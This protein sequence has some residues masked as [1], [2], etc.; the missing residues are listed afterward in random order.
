MFPD[1]VLQQLGLY[2][3]PPP[4]GPPLALAAPPA[5]PEPEPLPVP[6]PQRGE[7]VVPKEA[8]GQPGALGQGGFEPPPASDAPP[9]APAAPAAPA[10]PQQP[11]TAGQ[12][13][14]RAQQ[15][16]GQ[17]DVAG[18]EAIAA[19]RDVA[20]QK[21]RDELAAIHD[22]DEREKQ[23]EEQRK[24][25]ADETTKVRAQKQAYVAT[26]LQEAN[27]HRIDRDKHLKEMGIGAKIGW[28]I[29]MIMSNIG[30]ALQGRG[31]GDAVL[32]MLQKQMHDSVVAQMDER[33]RLRAKNS[34]AQHDLD[35]Y[36]QFSKDRMAQIAL[37]SAQNEKRL[38]N[39]FRMAGAKAAEPAAQAN[40]LDAVA[41]LEKS[42][43]ENA[44]KAAEFAAGHE[45]QR[46]QLAVS[47]GN[48]AVSRANQSLAERRFTHDVLKDTADVDLRRQQIENEAKKLERQGRTDEAKLVR[49]RSV[50]GEVKLVPVDPKDVRPG[51]KTITKDGKTFRSELGSITN[52]KGDVWIPTGTDT[53]VTEF[54]KS[55]EA[56]LKVLGAI[57]ALRQLGP[58]WMSNVANSKKL[59]EYRTEVADGVLEMVK[60]KG[61]GV[62]Q[63]H[64]IEYAMKGLGSGEPGQWLDTLDAMNRARS[65]ILRN[66]NTSMQSRGYDKTWEGPPDPLAQAPTEP[67]KN[68][69]ALAEL[70]Q[71]PYPRA[72]PFTPN[73]NPEQQKQLDELSRRANNQD[74][75]AIAALVLLMQTGATPE[76]R[77]A[78]ADAF[79]ETRYNW[80]TPVPPDPVTTADEV[81]INPQ[82]LIENFHRKP[83]PTLPRTRNAPPP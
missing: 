8:F 51:D 10:A 79:G 16:Q 14:Q 41:K 33:D 38:A 78:A 1:E 25:A 26:T 6:E 67:S 65:I 4:V 5:L 20:R 75:D 11:M 82:W 63:K 56:G 18:A 17:A 7:F 72:A 71:R 31:G 50:G 22:F 52:R 73:I 36:D 12:Q 27:N 80:P 42:S 43:A 15:K 24:A 44:Q 64:D 46:K 13:L 62:P 32:E 83:E 45:I 23:I 29:A 30:A 28:G 70:Q 81:G 57:D 35:K 34:A 68:Q 21:A 60:Y 59:Q 58:E 47:Q 40:A 48:L 66:M 9:L 76:I 37:L 55:H 39:M 3:Q 49:E 54:Q 61:M 53:V 69:K 74:S 77:D 2:Q 19:Q